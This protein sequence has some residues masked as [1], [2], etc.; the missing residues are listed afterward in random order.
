M[1][2]TR[3]TIVILISGKAGSG[4]TTIA[5]TLMQKI[6]DIPSITI[7]RYSFANPIKYMCK[8]F[9]EWDGEKDEKGRKL[10]QEQGRI[11]REYKPDIWA[12]HFINQLDKNTQVFPFNF[13][14]IDDWRFPNELAYLRNNPMLEV[15]TV[16]VFGRGGLNGGVALDVSEN[17]L[18]E[19]TGEWL[20]NE[21]NKE[22][23]NLGYDYSINNDSDLE[24]LN[25]KL[26]IILA[27][28]ENNYVIE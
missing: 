19:A 21:Y 14:I 10:L 18:P 6:Q 4:K 9:A 3:K 20:S 8:A 7:F 16:R 2:R 26:D 27:E 28:I 12:K 17:S 11:Y 25:S 13:S 5:E 24:L 1:P 23:Y 22:P 15:V